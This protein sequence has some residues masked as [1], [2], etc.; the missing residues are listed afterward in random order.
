MKLLIY[1]TLSHNPHLNLAFESYLLD[2]AQADAHILYLWQN[3]S[4]IVIGRSQ[5]P[6]LECHTENN[7]SR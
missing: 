4:V 1:Q 2:T 3:S 7:D 6:W 5:N